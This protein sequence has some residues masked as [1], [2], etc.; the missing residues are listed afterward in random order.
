MNRKEEL[1]ALLEE[2]NRDEN[3]ES[4]AFEKAE[5]K[6]KKKKIFL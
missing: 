5:K 3:F 1:N 4:N 2:F 6:I